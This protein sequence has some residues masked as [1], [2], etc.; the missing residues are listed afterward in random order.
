MRSTRVRALATGLA[1]EAVRNAIPTESDLADAG[2]YHSEDGAQVIQELGRV[3][4]EL[5][6]ESLRLEA[7]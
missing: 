1:A 4:N 5:L 3:A 2:L 7:L 6:A